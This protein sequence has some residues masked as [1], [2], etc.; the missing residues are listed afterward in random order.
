MMKTVKERLYH[1]EAN[2]PSAMWKKISDELADHRVVELPSRKKTKLIAL[3]TASAAVIILVVINLVYMNK[4]GDHS[5][6]IASDTAYK[7]QMEKNNELLESIIKAPENQKLVASR[8]IAS[9]GMMTYFTIKGTEGEPVRISPKVATLIL[10]ADNE[11]P[12]KPVW[13]KKINEWQNIM[14]SNNATPASANLIEIIQQ[15]SNKM[16]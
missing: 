6:K 14:L 4:S 5:L 15:A 8:N 12:P 7:N 1:F 9:E 11:Y 3:L 16:R 2:P 13:D 10:S